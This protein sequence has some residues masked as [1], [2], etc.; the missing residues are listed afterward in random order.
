MHSNRYSFLC[1]LM[2]SLRGDE[3]D[4]ETKNSQEGRVV[5]LMMPRSPS[6]GGRPRRSRS[7][8]FGGNLPVREGISFVLIQVSS[9]RR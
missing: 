4:L 1:S 7:R 8:S 9:G 6:L 3:M 2:R 5:G